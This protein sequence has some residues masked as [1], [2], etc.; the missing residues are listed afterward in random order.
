MVVDH[1][2][3]E[4]GSFSRPGPEVAEIKG[5]ANKRAAQRVRSST[6]QNEMR[7]PGSSNHRLCTK[8]SQFYKFLRDKS[9]AQGCVRCTEDDREHNER[10]EELRDFQWILR[11]P[12]S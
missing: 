5:V 12:V 1:G 6:V 9:L 4:V 10:K 2:A 8:D 7:C 3:P 11:Q